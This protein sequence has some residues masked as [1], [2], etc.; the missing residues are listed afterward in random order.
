V[1]KTIEPWMAKDEEAHLGRLRE[2]AAELRE[3]AAISEDRA[4]EIV[5]CPHEIIQEARSCYEGPDGEGDYMDIW[6]TQ[7]KCTMCG[8]SWYRYDDEE[9]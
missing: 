8:F 6:G 2:N 7:Y 5:A 4:D 3:R 9:D 1:S